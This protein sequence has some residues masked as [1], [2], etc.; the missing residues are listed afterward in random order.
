M[1]NVYGKYGA[2]EKIQ[3]QTV[4][5]QRHNMSGF[6]GLSWVVC[7]WCTA[8]LLILSL[9]TFQATAVQ[10]LSGN[11]AAVHTLTN[12]CI[13]THTHT[14]HTHCLYL[15]TLITLIY[16]IH[17]SE[18]NYNSIMCDTSTTFYHQQTKVA[19]FN[20]NLGGWGRI[21]LLKL[22]TGITPQCFKLQ[23]FLKLIYSSKNV[24]E[25]QYILLSTFERKTTF[26]A[27]YKPKSA[28]NRSFFAFLYI[29]GGMGVFDFFD[30]LHHHP[31]TGHAHCQ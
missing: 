28:W 29:L 5:V 4:C 20:P 26:S 22:W 18:K 11:P 30:F 13:H 14:V 10:C 24:L 12:V 8:D 17:H 27:N 1:K 6:V 25:V 2:V 3:T 15:C 16:I 21:W 9:P 19:S 31:L 23:K 7:N